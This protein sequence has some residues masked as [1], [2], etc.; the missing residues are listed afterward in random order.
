L[1]AAWARRTCALLAAA[2]LPVA[3]PGL[4]EVALSGRW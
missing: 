2:V 4:A 3:S 1:A